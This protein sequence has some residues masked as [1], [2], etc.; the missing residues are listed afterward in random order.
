MFT[1]EEYPYSTV[2]GPDPEDMAPDLEE[3]RC[4]KCGH[5]IT[6]VPII[7][8]LS[9]TDPLA[10]WNICESCLTARLDA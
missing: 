5:E 6:V 4:S 7:R 1:T 10:M 2:D 9:E 3:P 8:V